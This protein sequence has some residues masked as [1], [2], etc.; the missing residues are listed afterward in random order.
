MPK[1]ICTKCNCEKDYSEFHKHKQCKDGINSVCK[2]CRKP[3]S[4]KQYQQTSIEYRLWNSARGRSKKKGLDFNIEVSDIV[5]PAQCPVF[6]TPFS[7]NTWYAASLDRIDPK[8]G[9]VKGN[10]QIMS[11]RANMLKNDATVEELQKIL[12]FI[13]KIRSEIQNS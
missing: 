2:Q 1:R 3:L 13:S 6:G 10:V 12:E 4:S 9:Y 11:R 7:R 5:I 8:Q